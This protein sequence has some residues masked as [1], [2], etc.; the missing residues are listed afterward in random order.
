MDRHMPT[1]PLRNIL[2]HLTLILLTLLL[3]T[4]LLLTGPLWVWQ[5]GE[6]ERE[7]HW[8]A[9]SSEI[10]GLPE[11]KAELDETVVQVYGA[12][13]YRWRGAFADHTWIAIKKAGEEAF[14]RYEVIGWRYFRGMEVIRST[15]G[16]PDRAWFGNPPRLFGEQRGQAAEVLVGKVESAIWSY[17]YA[18]FYRVWPGP[19]SNTFVAHVLRSVPELG[20]ALPPTAIGKDFPLNGWI[21]PTP[22]G[23]GWQWTLWGLMGVSFGWQEGVRVQWMALEFGLNPW[24]GELYWPGIG[25]VNLWR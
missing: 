22:A 23:D 7:R 18:D 8:S 3:L 12:R 4:L 6:L 14:T 25:V 16:A 20:V 11:A 21:Q 15:V 17:P 13:A 10:Q 1:S 19:N 5:F 9:A 24:R 2:R